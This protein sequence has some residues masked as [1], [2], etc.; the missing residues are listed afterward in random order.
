MFRPDMVKHTHNDNTVEPE[1]DE[2]WWAQGPY[3][4]LH[5]SLFRKNQKEKIY[6][7]FKSL[8]LGWSHGVCIQG[9]YCLLRLNNILK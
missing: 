4:L 9:P 2:L 5:E 3:G 8:S 7:Y 1:V 6:S